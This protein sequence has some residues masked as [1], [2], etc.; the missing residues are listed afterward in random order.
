MLQHY[1]GEA[2][3]VFTE[4]P[5]FGME[6]MRPLYQKIPFEVPYFSPAEVEVAEGAVKSPG[7]LLDVFAKSLTSF[8]DP[9]QPAVK[10]NTARKGGEIF[11]V[12]RTNG[13]GS[14]F[15]GTVAHGLQLRMLDLVGLTDPQSPK[16]YSGGKAFEM[17][18]VNVKDLKQAHGQGGETSVRGKVESPSPPAPGPAM[19]TRALDF[20]EMAGVEELRQGKNV[21]IRNK[22]KVIRMLG[23]LRAS[24]ECLKC[25]T[26]AS[27]GDLL[28]AFSYTFVDVNRA[29]TKEDQKK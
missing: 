18:R 4:I 15:R 10:P 24:E 13:F 5:G 9:A 22:D 21:Y 23:A 29:L 25:H 11:P 7:P 12:V 27:K 16:A 20:F 1:H 2:T 19:E 17:V 3:H 14:S 8:Q 6:R 28:G 26:D